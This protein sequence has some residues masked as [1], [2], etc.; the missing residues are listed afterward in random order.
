MQEKIKVVVDDPLS[1]TML[2]YLGEPLIIISPVNHAGWRK[3][4]CII[5]N[6]VE[7]HVFTKEIQEFVTTN[8]KLYRNNKMRHWRW[9]EESIDEDGSSVTLWSVN[10]RSNNDDEGEEE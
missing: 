4:S 8:L 10:L 6:D 5:P 9:E 3:L 1:G 7:E 2:T